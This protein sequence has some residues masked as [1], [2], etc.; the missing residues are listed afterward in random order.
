M[1]LAVFNDNTVSNSG[2]HKPMRWKFGWVGAGEL[3]LAQLSY[4]RR[5]LGAF[6]HILPTRPTC[7][8]HVRR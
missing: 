3:T 4:S 1:T 2:Q 7:G 6:A 8:P 5:G